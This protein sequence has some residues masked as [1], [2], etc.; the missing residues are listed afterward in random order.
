MAYIYKK[1]LDHLD[2]V[3]NI[4]VEA[5]ERISINIE[6]YRLHLSVDLT[7]NEAMKLAKSIINHYNA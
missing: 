5:N 2:E 1:K 4:D 3:I 7:K 6:N